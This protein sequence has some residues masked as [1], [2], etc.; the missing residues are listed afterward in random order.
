MAAAG[1][2]GH[3]RR[4]RRTAAHGGVR[5]T[6][7]ASDYDYDHDYEQPEPDEVSLVAALPGLA[8]IGAVAS[9]RLIEWSA[10]AYVR[11]A[12]RLVR[13]AANGEAAGDVLQRTGEDLVAFFRHLL[14]P[15]AGGPPGAAPRPGTPRRPPA[16]PSAARP[17]S[18]SSTPT[19][20]RPLP[21]CAPAAPSSCAARPTSSP[22]TRA[23]PIPPT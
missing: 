3:A 19:S 9:I 17:P 15:P 4:G 14:A 12:T 8:R 20:A 1:P 13:A 18:R 21:R 7:R 6:R 5:M 2:R 16:S 23:R 11:T 22:T 10:A